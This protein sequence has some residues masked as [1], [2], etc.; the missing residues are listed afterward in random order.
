MTRRSSKVAPQGQI[1]VP[2]Q[3]PADAE[4]KVFVPKAGGY[5]ALDIHRLLFPNPPKPHTLDELKQGIGD[6]IRK[7]HKRR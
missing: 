4:E 1:P 5:S 6:Y 7:K 3:D 2:G